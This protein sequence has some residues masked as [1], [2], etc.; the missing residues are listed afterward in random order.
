MYL[1]TCIQ[2]AI[3]RKKKQGK[4]SLEGNQSRQFLNMTEKL[5]KAFN[6]AG[7]S[8]AS[9]GKP[10]LASLKSFSKVVELAFQ[11]DLKEGYQE[12]I[13]EFE[14][15]YMELGVSVTPKVNIL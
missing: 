9:K 7:E 15:N 4:S 14:L 11:V 12:S 6:E 5:E 10:F 8:V 13:R 1:L 2:N 3:V